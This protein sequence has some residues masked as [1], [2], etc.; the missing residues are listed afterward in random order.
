MDKHDSTGAMA[1][2]YF[3]T[4]GTTRAIEA[5]YSEKAKEDTLKQ[6]PKAVENAQ[7]S[8]FQQLMGDYPEINAQLHNTEEP[9]MSGQQPIRADLEK[10]DFTKTYVLRDSEF[11]DI[12]LQPLEGGKFAAIINHLDTERKQ[13]LIYGNLY[14]T[15][16]NNGQPHALD[17]IE[18][19]AWHTGIR[20]KAPQLLRKG[21]QYR[22]RH[23]PDV[24]ATVHEYG[25]DLDSDVL[26]GLRG[27]NIEFE[28]RQTVPCDGVR[29]TERTSRALGGCLLDM[30]AYEEICS[31][32]KKGDPLRLNFRELLEKP[33][34]FVYFDRF[35]EIDRRIYVTG[36]KKDSPTSAR[37]L[38]I[39]SVALLTERDVQETHPGNRDAM[40][41]TIQR[42][43]KSWSNN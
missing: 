33:P 26:V 1:N 32:W 22:L 13:L 24:L 38:D 36:E 4:P 34:A 8:G 35:D 6:N 14:G 10:I 27:P 23:V 43:K 12:M 30:Y 19:M 28:I 40:R 39:H 37:G 21:Q 41:E 15:Y 9:N 20:D 2:A 17:L 11:C 5:V 3:G 7:S 25:R 31:T 29:C 16:L 42:M 18:K